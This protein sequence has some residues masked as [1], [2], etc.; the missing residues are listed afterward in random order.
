MRLSFPVCTFSLC[1]TASELANVHDR[2][3]VISLLC[4][5]ICEFMSFVCNV[6]QAACVFS[7]EM[8]EVE[9]DK[10]GSCE[11]PDAMYVKLVSSDGHEFIIKREHA[12]TSGTIKAMLSGPGQCCRHLLQLQSLYA[13]TV[14]A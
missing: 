1:V 8:A 14:I 13:I 4:W 2:L 7:E 10:F 6:Q 3:S 9:E 5:L 11:G 12:L